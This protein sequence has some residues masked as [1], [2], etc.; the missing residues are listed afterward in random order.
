MASQR[1]DEDGI[2]ALAR[3]YA[4]KLRKGDMVFLIGE[5]GSGK[6]VFAK[7]LL[8]SLGV[9]GDIPSPSYSLIQTYDLP[10]MPF[11]V[12]HCDFF[13][14]DD[15]SELRELGLGEGLD[16][17]ALVIEWPQIALPELLKEDIHWKQGRHCYTVQLEFDPEPG[18]RLVAISDRMELEQK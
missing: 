10:G 9:E 13:R 18:W 11:P 6:T 15:P 12:W 1:L 8:H 7:S 2:C 3:Q 5:L 16:Q 14:L 4:Q 17:A